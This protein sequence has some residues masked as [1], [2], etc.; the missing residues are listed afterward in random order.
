MSDRYE[1]RKSAKETEKIIKKAKQDM[2]DWLSGLQEV[3]SEFEVRA[4]Q[5]G[6]LAGVN[7]ASN[8]K[9]S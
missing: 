3:P 4:W 7:M 8:R 6:Y 5:S 9:E 2:M 1:K